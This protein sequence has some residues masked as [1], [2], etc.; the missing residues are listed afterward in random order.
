[1]G[2]IKL[3]MTKCYFTNFFRRMPKNNNTINHNAVCMWHMNFYLHCR[4]GTIPLCTP[5]PNRTSHFAKLVVRYNA[6][7]STHCLHMKMNSVFFFCLIYI[8]TL[9]IYKLSEF[10]QIG[11]D[12]FGR[13]DHIQL[14]VCCHGN[15]KDCNTMQT[16]TH[17]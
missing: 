16:L 5:S 12:V 1:M 11:G 15:G 9:K 6:K 17:I 7:F 14:S 2:L 8:L 3:S 4:G 13:R 10:T